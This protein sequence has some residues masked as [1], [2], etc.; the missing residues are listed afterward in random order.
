MS[1]CQLVEVCQSPRIQISTPIG[2]SNPTIDEDRMSR[3]VKSV[4]TCMSIHTWQGI[5]VTSSWHLTIFRILLPLFNSPVPLDTG[6]CLIVQSLST[7]CQRQPAVAS[8]VSS[9]PSA[10][11]G[12]SDPSQSAQPR[13]HSALVRWHGKSLVPCSEVYTDKC[14]LALRNRT[15]GVKWGRQRYL[16]L[17][18]VAIDINPDGNPPSQTVCSDERSVSDNMTI[19]RLVRLPA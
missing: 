16:G 17:P 2:H 13:R 5:L 12:F 1:S 4:V 8:T 3:I 19:W 6:P 10:G 11:I 18:G 9:L 7:C 15:T 14:L